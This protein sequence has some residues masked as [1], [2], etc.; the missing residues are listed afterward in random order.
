MLAMLHMGLDLDLKANA[1]QKHVF[2]NEIQKWL[3]ES[4]KISLDSLMNKVGV[5]I[6]IIK[7]Q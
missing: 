5:K 3:A 6:I 2:F 1:E 7:L 4:L